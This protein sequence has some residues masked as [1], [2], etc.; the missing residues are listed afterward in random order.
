MAGGNA[1]RDA[2][3][4]LVLAAAMAFVLGLALSVAICSGRIDSL[5]VQLASLG[6]LIQMNNTENP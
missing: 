2:V 6:V 3:T 1:G 4:D 5:N